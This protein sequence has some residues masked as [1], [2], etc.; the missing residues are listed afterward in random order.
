MRSED[1]A[2]GDRR[3]GVLAGVIV[4]AGLGARIWAASGTFLNPDEALH[5]RLANQSSVAL[6]YRQSLTALH[7]PLLI[8][9]LHFWRELGSSELWLRM[10]SVIAGTAFC[11]F[12]YKWLTL[13]AGRTAGLIGLMLVALVP[14]EIAIA[15]EVRQYA[16]VLAFL[17]ASLYLLERAFVSESVGSMLGSM[18]FLYLAMLTHYSAFLFAG[19]LGA[20]GLAKILALRPRGGVVLS[21][22]AG[23][24]GGLGLCLFLY[25]THLSRQ[26][27]GNAQIYR[28]WLGYLSRSSYFEGGRENA[29]LYAVGHSFGVFQYLF[30]QLAVGIV[31]GLAFLAGLGL[32]LRGRRLGENVEL[33]RSLAILLVVPFVL[34]CGGS[35]AHVYPYGGTRQ[36]AFLMIPAAAGVSVAMAWLARGRMEWGM[37]MAGLVVLACLAF[38]K[39]RQPVM[40]RG[41]QSRAHM[42]AAMEFV[43]TKIDPGDLIFTDYQSDLI[44]GQYLCAGRE[45]PLEKAPEGFEQF[46]AGGAMWCRA[47]SGNGRWGA[48]DFGAEWKSLVQSYGLKPETTVWVF[49]AGWGAE[50]GDE[51]RD[52]GERD[53]QVESFGKNIKVFRWQG[54]RVSAFQGFKDFRASV[55]EALVSSTLLQNLAL[56]IRGL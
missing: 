9:L 20:Y 39:A 31:M 35:F 11:W 52:G 54:F 14:P 18:L 26:D 19:A 27:F 28:V 22:I 36:I 49:Q 7:P 29:V 24:C 44:L 8:L 2:G 55:V 13:A 32:I 21:W 33:S 50:L 4:V 23:E 15:A 42:T 38:G 25:K 3:G 6:A 41:D 56:R 30:G 45:V 40:E 47:T 5:V 17:S 46:L 37:G 1:G 10:P 34:A 16:L 43:Q 53:L 51:L 12:L 48:D